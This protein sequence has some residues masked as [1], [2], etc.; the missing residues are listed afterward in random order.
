[1]P[2]SILQRPLKQSI[3]TYSEHTCGHFGFHQ[4]FIICHQI[5]VLLFTEL[6]FHHLNK[7]YLSDFNLDTR[8]GTNPIRRSKLLCC[9][10]LPLMLNNSM[11]SPL[12]T[13]DGTWFH[14]GTTATATPDSWFFI[15]CTVVLYQY[16]KPKVTSTNGTERGIADLHSFTNY[17]FHFNHIFKLL[18]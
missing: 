6:L 16:R 17:S 13:K 14:F 9:K 3:Q 12:I 8:S 11:R 10:G 5:M 7:M 2:T 4:L 18:K 1:M 15:G